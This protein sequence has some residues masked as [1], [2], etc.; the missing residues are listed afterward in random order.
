MVL[1]RSISTSDVLQA[2]ARA[3]PQRTAIVDEAGSLTYHE[4]DATVDRLAAGLQRLG[5]AAGDRVAYLLWNQRELLL[6]YFSIARLGALTVSLNF[7][8]TAEELAYQLAA[9]KCKALIVDEDLA[10]LAS[11]AIAISTLPI[12]QIVC[13]SGKRPDRLCFNDLLGGNTGNI[14]LFPIVSSDADSGI[15]FTSGTTGRPKGA[16]VKHRSAVAAAML[17]A[18]SIRI[19]EPIRI[20]GVAPLFHRGAMENVA[21]SVV[22]CGGTQFLFK[23]LN[24][25]QT[26]EYLEKFEINTAFVVPTMAWQLLRELSAETKA[27]PHLVNWLSASAPLPPIL[28]EQIIER[29][30]LPNGIINAYGITEMLIVSACPPSMLSKKPGSAG[31]PVPLTRVAIYDE[32]RGVLPDGDVGEILISGPTAFSRYLDNEQATREAIINLN[33][34]EWY[35][36]GDVGV[37]DEDGYL[38]IKDRKKDMIISGGENVYC[39]E[40]ELALIE[41]PL[42][43]DVAVVGFPDER[44]GEIVVAA[45]VKATDELVKLDDIA[46]SCA[47][48]ASY[49]RPREVICLEM[50]PRNSFGKVRKDLV[51]AMVHEKLESSRQILRAP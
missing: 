50:L 32:K 46:T 19:S 38:A 37:L 42:V 13:G 27:L 34:Q 20:L 18:C 4:F 5:V 41:H 30:K 24:A 33:G 3:M 31:L 10:E 15:W 9:A 21:L 16:V 36:S 17:G 7:R 51:R 39:A 14:P 45:I 29:F 40:V 11:Q 43:R 23:K 2:T 28:A 48:L 35:R 1:D 25:T 26:L 47:S 12:L 6:S 44:W 8:L 22:M 49:K